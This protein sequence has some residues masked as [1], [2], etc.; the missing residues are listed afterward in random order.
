MMLGVPPNDDRSRSAGR[1]P[2]TLGL[3]LG[4]TSASGAGVL[5]TPIRRS[6][7]SAARSP[8]SQ[9]PPTVPHNVSCAASPANQIV[10]FT[11]SIMMRRASWA[12]G[13]A[14]EAAPSVKAS[15]FQR[16]ACVRPIAFLISAP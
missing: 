3:G 1:V 8:D 5:S 2:F 6:T 10:S 4:V 12:P 9:A 15:A 11:G 13:T 14:A 7:A 16:V